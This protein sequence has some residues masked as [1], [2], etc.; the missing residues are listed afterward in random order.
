MTAIELYRSGKLQEAIQVLG[1]ELRSS[2]LDTKRR[3]F[4]FELLCFAGLYDRAEKQLDFLAKDGGQRAAGVLL[5]R[6]AIQAERT[7]QDL[8]AKREYPESHAAAEPTPGTWNDQPFTELRDADPRIGA[9]LE[10]FIAGGY[11]R[12]PMQYMERL[13]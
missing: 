5:Y 8:F 13:E 9:N 2:P 12:I 7:R 4:L 11:T 10:V 6:S 1:D 3:T